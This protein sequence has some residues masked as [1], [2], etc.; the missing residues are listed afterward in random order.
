MD[1]MAEIIPFHG[2]RYDPGRVTDI[3]RVVTQPYDKISPQM[4]ARYLEGDPH[5]I[6]RIIGNEDH[7]EAA[8]YLAQWI[9]EGILVRDD[10]PSFYPYEQRFRFD[11]ET[12][13]RTGLIGLIPLEDE[14]IAVR[15]HERVLSS[16]LEDRLGLIRAT[17]ANEGL[18]FMLYSDPS[19]AV[20]QILAEFR[21]GTAPCAALSDEYDANHRIW[22]VQER[23]LQ[24]DLSE[25]LRGLPLYIADGHHRFRSAQMYCRE[26]R[27]KGWQA[28]ATESFDKRM[29][30][31]FNMES[32]GLRILPTHRG[33]RGLKHLDMAG[34]LKSLEPDFEVTRMPDPDRLF[35]EMPGKGGRIGMTCRNGYYL[36][37]VREERKNDP[38]FMPG[39]TAPARHLDV[40]VLH[41]GI[42]SPSL[43]VGV[44]ELASQSHVDYF[45]DRQELLERLEK[46]DLQ[47][48]FFLNPTSL[49]QVREISERGDSMPQKSTDFY[50]KLLTGLVLM[51]MEIR[52]S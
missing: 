36:L 45:R 31:L 17:E 1:L 27:E 2:Y 22:R 47:L 30:A 37:S 39:I 26:C 15:G 28:A 9:Q 34:F 14:D 23:K 24:R 35:K 44:S 42:L 29:A 16:P 19:L 20:E 13:S 25:A 48:G 38:A 18:I 51:K 8:R 32:P 50:P 7:A 40:T 52:K 41:E 21:D 11:G 12:L 3:G 5:N 10:S 4:K 46:G 6:V 49:Q 43:G 33:L